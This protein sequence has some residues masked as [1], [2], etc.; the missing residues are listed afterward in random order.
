MPQ[1]IPLD[2]VAPCVGG[3]PGRAESRCEARREWQKGCASLHD[4]SIS[5]NQIRK[6]FI[7]L[8]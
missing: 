8:K 4:Y 2:R 3:L 1:L 7:V 5:V 6:N